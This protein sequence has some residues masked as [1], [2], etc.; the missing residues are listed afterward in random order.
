M[1]SG[2]VTL[3]A[4]RPTDTEVAADILARLRKAMEPVLAIMDEAARAGFLV[5]WAGLQP[6]AFGH[7]EIAALHLE[8]HIY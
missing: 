2:L 5:R 6:N 1:E 7:H 3:A 4:S 8:R